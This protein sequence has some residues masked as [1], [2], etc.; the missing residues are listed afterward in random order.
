MSEYDSVPLDSS[1]ITHSS[2]LRGESPR[3][4]CH[5][6]DEIPRTLKHTFGWLYSSTG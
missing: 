5:K 6:V 3:D 2:F 4:H 1:S